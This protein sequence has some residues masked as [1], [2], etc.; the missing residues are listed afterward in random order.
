MVW[1]RRPLN[2]DPLAAPRRFVAKHAFAY[3]AVIFG[4]GFALGSLRV[5]LL[6]PQLGERNAELAEAPLMLAGIYVAARC[7]AR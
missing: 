1:H 2:A 5:L 6:A 3:F 4:L 7:V